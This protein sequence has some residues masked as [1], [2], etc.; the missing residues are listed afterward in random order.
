MNKLHGP[1]QDLQDRVLLTG[2]DGEWESKGVK[3]IFRAENGGV[4]VWYDT[5]HTIFSQG[6]E[7]AKRELEGEFFDVV[8]PS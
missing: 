7:E 4:L 5:T 8:V 1:F 3:R 6:R 2:F